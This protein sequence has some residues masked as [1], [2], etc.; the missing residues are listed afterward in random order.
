M[1]MCT[2]PTC[3]ATASEV[4]AVV[5]FSPMRKEDDSLAS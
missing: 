4:K 1:A 2:P 3:V 5:G